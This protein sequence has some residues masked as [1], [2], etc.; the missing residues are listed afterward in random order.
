MASLDIFIS[1][2]PF[3]C[4]SLY[5]LEE[6]PYCIT[7][8]FCGVPGEILMQKNRNVSMNYVTE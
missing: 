1:Q 2:I 5:E 4:A 6:K 7:N 3:G 8:G